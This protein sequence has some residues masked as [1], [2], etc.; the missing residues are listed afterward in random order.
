MKPDKTKDDPV[1]VIGSGLAGL[2]AAR[3]LADSLPVVI[4]TK[5]GLNDSNTQ[6]SQGGI[7]AV[8]SNNDSSGLHIKDT[9]TAGRGLCDKEAVS[10]LSHKS[11]TAIQRLIQFGVFFDKDNEGNYLLGLE[12]AHS[13]PRILYAGGDAT[14]AE[15][16]RALAKNA[17]RHPNIDIVE[18]AHV[19]R[20]ECERGS[21]SGLTYYNGSHERVFLKCRQVV[22]ATGGAGRL[23]R[24][25]SN[26][27]TAT[28]EGCVLAYN[29]GAELADLEFYQFHPSGLRLE[30]APNFLIS[31]AVRGEGAILRNSSGEPIMEGVHPLKDLAPRDIVARTI[32]REQMKST[33]SGVFLDACKIDPEKLK[34]RFP[35]IFKSCLNYGI[36]IRKDPIPVTPVAHYMIGGVSSDLHGRATLP[37]LYSIGETSR[38]GVH[39]ANR[40]AS[41][42]LLECAVFS[43]E[44]AEAVIADRERTPDCWMVKNKNCNTS[45]KRKNNKNNGISLK[46]LQE[47]MWS[48]VGLIR[49]RSSL[50]TMVD[51]LRHLPFDFTG[52]FSPE[53]FELYAM[54]ALGR[55]I[56]LSA[57]QRE[58]S[59]GSHFRSDFPNPDDR[60]LYPI[61]RQCDADK[62]LI[63]SDG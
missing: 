9:L 38:T 63:E 42:S 37:G 40:L 20:L 53:R 52:P 45:E 60:F 17:T 49:C 44:A 14:G 51:L 33:G 50:Q 57:L 7:A 12:G 29:A 23:F 25:T 47:L 6:H 1:A 58:E 11:K 48:N 39:G 62:L 2:L 54:K 31:E 30:G 43:I 34:K 61:K 36:D 56:A 28:G 18:H 21:I 13:I 27:E 3:M 24:Y 10:F 4:L 16:Q 5:K 55:L 8:W 59:R 35:T 32:A 46:K 19:T 15:I 26:P 41:N 22:L